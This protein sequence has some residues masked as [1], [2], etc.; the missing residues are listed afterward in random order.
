MRGSA[1]TAETFEAPAALVAPTG[2]RF[3]PVELGASLERWLDELHAGPVAVILGASCNGLSFVRSLGRRGIPTLL[4]DSER[5]LGMH[6][7]FGE[8]ALL[9]DAYEDP[10]GCASFLEL[11]GARLAQ[12]GVILATSDV[13]TLLLAT[14]EERLRRSF[15]FLVP[16]ADTVQ[17]ILNKRLQYEFAR[18][19]G[20]P[21]PESF[22][23][24]SVEE[25]RRVAA[26]VRYP[27]LLKPYDSH[28]AWSFL[29]GKKVIAVES[30]S[31]LIAEFERVTAL[32]VPLM[33]QDY[34]PGED[35]ALLGYLAF[36]DRER[37]ERAWITKQKLRQ[38]PPQFGDG[39]LTISVDAPDV[40]AL[41][42]RLLDACGYQGFVGV[43]FKYDERDA[44]YRLIEI[45]PRTVSCNE[46]A[47][48]AGVDFPWIGYENVTGSDDGA[49]SVI[50]S[51]RNLTFVNE[52]WDVK[53]FLA[54]RRAGKL[55]LVGWLWSLR[56]VRATATGAWD[57]PLPLLAGI[58]QL[59]GLSK[60][61]RRWLARGDALSAARRRWTAQRPSAG[62]RAR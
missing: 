33:I 36:W 52:Q 61:R 48:R 21:I 17:M 11:V 60:R 22:F 23:P 3:A 20:V 4:L 58:W 54:L 27:C 25:A 14:Y 13:H 12:P 30:S 1:A 42:R 49:A 51:R 32:G 43:E 6:T 5:S 46:L 45:N 31:E 26:E 24:E 29:D 41:G 7:R 35:S 47:I 2:G 15:R 8:V 9:P 50:R 19:V 28:H 39:A 53:A 40:A 16:E 44:T 10:D 38:N 55:S 18:S 59:T 57:D 62:R 56:G 34:I 37:R